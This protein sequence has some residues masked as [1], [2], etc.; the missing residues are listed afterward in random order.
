MTDKPK[1]RKL[2][3]KDL[4]PK[5]TFGGHY[6]PET[7]TKPVA[8]KVPEPESA[9][10]DTAPVAE[11]PKQVEKPV[12]AENTVEKT[13]TAKQSE[14]GSVKNVSITL[15]PLESHKADLDALVTEK[16]SVSDIVRTAGRKTIRE[17]SPSS[18]FVPAQDV[19]RLGLQ[20]ALR[21][22]KNVE[23]A[24]LKKLHDENN[25]LELHSDFTMIRGQI[26]PIFWNKL[27]E[28]IEHLKR[29]MK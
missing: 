17:F 21:T 20:Y 13:E 28:L 27:D 2:S 5:A 1:R 6:R 22:S 15:Y 18:T 14:T 19:K 8:A 7:T 16:I 25:P 11:K 3:I 24:T 29:R 23:S 9:A 10:K 26:E 12:R 4:D